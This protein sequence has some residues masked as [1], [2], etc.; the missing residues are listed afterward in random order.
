[1]IEA[2]SKLLHLL[3]RSAREHGL[4]AGYELNELVG[5]FFSSRLLPR[6]AALGTALDC[7]ES[8]FCDTSLLRW[9]YLHYEVHPLQHPFLSHFFQAMPSLPH[10]RPVLSILHKALRRL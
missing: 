8:Y 9:L 1:M 2:A 6:P 5:L 4:A 10:P 3:W 7:F